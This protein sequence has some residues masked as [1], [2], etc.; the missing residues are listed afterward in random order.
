MCEGDGVWAFSLAFAEFEA[1]SRKQGAPFPIY[2]F[3]VPFT[4]FSSFRLSSSEMAHVRQVGFRVYVWVCLLASVL[5][6]VPA[7]P[8]SL[9][10]S[11]VAGRSMVRHLCWN[12]LPC[13]VA[14]QGCYCKSLNA[15]ALSSN[16]SRVRAICQVTANFGPDFCYPPQSLD[17]RPVSPSN[18][19]H[20][21][22]ALFHFSQ[23]LEREWG[24]SLTYNVYTWCMGS[25]SCG[26]QGM[27]EVKIFVPES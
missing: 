15:L 1:P 17:W 6:P 13:T 10:V 3:T 27:C 21:P 2:S 22:L 26:M 7:P 9:R 23:K 4:V 8:P 25:W 14:L 20:P 19:T 16:L 18:T 11:P 12:I 5:G 24:S